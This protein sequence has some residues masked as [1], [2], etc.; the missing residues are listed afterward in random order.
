METLTLEQAY[1]LGEL[2]GVIAVVAS[3]IYLALQLRQNTLSIRM[4]NVQ[5]LSSQ[6][7][8]FVDM[9]AQSEELADIFLRGLEDMENLAKTERI[10]F[11]M[12]VSH[13]F[14]ILFEQYLQMQY[15]VESSEHLDATVNSFKD[16]MQCPG[17]QQHWT[18]RRH[19]YTKGFQI[20]VD[21]II[22]G[23]IIG[24]KLTNG[25]PKH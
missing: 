16:L 23:G 21:R 3:L 12:I 9:I 5:A 13:M 17:V 6:Y 15:K 24:A 19:G 14:R 2:L 7:V 18:L 1:D 25:L 11:R 10:R 22:E 4:S 8:G 20:F